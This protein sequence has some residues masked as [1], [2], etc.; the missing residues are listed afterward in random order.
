MRDYYPEGIIKISTDT[1]M[2]VGFNNNISTI[3]FITTG[4]SVSNNDN[5][6]NTEKMK[7]MIILY[8]NT[9][10]NSARTCRAGKKQKQNR[11]YP[12]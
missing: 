5:N 11:L 6:N 2:R 9:P 3:F 8:A 7:K 1:P 10:A 4:Y 12:L